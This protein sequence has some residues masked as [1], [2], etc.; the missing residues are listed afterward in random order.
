MSFLGGCI[1]TSPR[2]S[3]FTCQDATLS[4]PPPTAP[5][6]QGC[7]P[8]GS[9]LPVAKARSLGGVHGLFPS[10]HAL[11]GAH[12]QA[13]TCLPPTYPWSPPVFCS[14]SASS[15]AVAVSSPACT[16]AP[17]LH[18][19]GRPPEPA[20]F[21][22][23]RSL[24]SVAQRGLPGTQVGLSLCELTQLL[25]PPSLVESRWR[26]GSSQGRGAPVP[27][28]PASHRCSLPSTWTKPLSPQCLPPAGPCAW[29]LLSSI[30]S[31]P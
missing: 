9:H 18:T 6:P 14:P 28:A 11:H 19:C 5:P 3:H 13:S 21:M 15:F 22:P 24:P 30:L 29:N 8:Q 23:L 16:P 2:T 7:V 1:W 4:F 10:P 31:L 12:H 25:P 26:K 17:G 27:P 20:S